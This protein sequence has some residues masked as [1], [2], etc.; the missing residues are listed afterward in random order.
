MPKRI[1]KLPSVYQVRIFFKK[2]SKDLYLY[3]NAHSDTECRSSNKMG[4]RKIAKQHENHPNHPWVQSGTV[5]QT[6]ISYFQKKVKIHFQICLVYE[7]YNTKSLILYRR[8][9]EHTF[10]FYLSESYRGEIKCQR[11]MKD[12][13]KTICIIVKLV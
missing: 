7:K 9:N 12:I 13:L 3:T 10:S 5:Y 11:Q 8:V 1:F 6:I 2:L 4:L